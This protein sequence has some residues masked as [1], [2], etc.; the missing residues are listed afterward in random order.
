MAIGM[1]KI[2]G[3]RMSFD[4]NIDNKESNKNNKKQEITNT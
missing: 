2:K 4:D 1:I 3:R